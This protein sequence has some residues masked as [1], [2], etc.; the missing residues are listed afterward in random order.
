ML[1]VPLEYPPFWS[2]NRLEE[3]RCLLLETAGRGQQQVAEMLSIPEVSPHLGPSADSAR[4]FCANT[5]LTYIHAPSSTSPGVRLQRQELNT[6]SHGV[7]PVTHHHTDRS[8]LLPSLTCNLP[9]HQGATR[10][11]HLPC[12][13]VQTQFQRT[14]TAVSELLTP[15]PSQDSVSGGLG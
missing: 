4:T 3:S 2:W 11:H 13:W 15:C 6:S 14:C 10:R 12:T 8:S 7:C 5:T 1:Q 9:P